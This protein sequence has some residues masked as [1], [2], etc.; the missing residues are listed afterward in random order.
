MGGFY[1]YFVGM[2]LPHLRKAG[3]LAGE[4][5]YRRACDE[6]DLWDLDRRL[7][8]LYYEIRTPG[9]AERLLAMMESGEGFLPVSS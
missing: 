4:P 9:R 6:L 3:Q 8:D 7:A 2:I 1:V 5:I